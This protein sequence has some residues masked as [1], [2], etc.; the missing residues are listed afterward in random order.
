VTD[1]LTALGELQV[2]YDAEVQRTGVILYVKRS[3]GTRLAGRFMLVS[4]RRRLPMSLN[5]R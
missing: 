2:P 5:T 3:L 4:Q 1:G